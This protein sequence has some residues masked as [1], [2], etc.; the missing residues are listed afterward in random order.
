MTTEHAAPS[1]ETRRTAPTRA[2]A[3]SGVA[4]GLASIAS[5]LLSTSLSPEHDTTR[6]LTAEAVTAQ[7]I[8]RQPLILTFHTVTVASALLL[9]VF[10]AG[11]RRRLA[12]G[13]P[14]DSIVP[15]VAFGGLLLVSA[16]QV[17]G[18]GLDTEFLFGLGDDAVLL[19][20]DIGMYSHWIATVPWL[21]AGGG[22][23]ALAVGAA[24]RAGDV[25]R[26]IGVTGFALG[27]LTVLL[28]VSPLQYMSAVPGALWLLV[29]AL[30]FLLGDRAHR[31]AETA[32]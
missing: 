16:A 32:E 29:T 8:E 7:L 17:L 2:W 11:L 13:L 3:I 4:A 22:L 26:G 23:A 12:G 28:A 27:G 31:R 19:P 18:S 14:R 20:G 9:V 30:A 10:A 25:P 6:A 24:S 5:V 15:A 1:R 21:W